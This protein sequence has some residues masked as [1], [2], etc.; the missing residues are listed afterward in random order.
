MA[1][2]TSARS[3]WLDKAIQWASLDRLSPKPPTKR[4]TIQ[5]GLQQFYSQHVETENEQYA[6]DVAE[7][8]LEA[9][10]ADD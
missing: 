7:L 9:A 3:G 4:L 2:K 6:A 8:N 1:T 5:Q 10:L